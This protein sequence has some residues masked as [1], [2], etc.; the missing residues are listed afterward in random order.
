MIIDSHAHLKHGDDAR[1]EY[2]PEAIIAAMDAAG[3]DRSVVF[4]MSTTTRRSVEMA[5]AAAERFPERLI[6]YAY[7]LPHAQRSILPE[8]EEAV[9][10]SGFRGF[11][12]HAGECR[13]ADYTTG[14]VFELASRLGVPC[15]VDFCGDAAAAETAAGSFQDTAI[16]IAHIGK[17]LCTDDALID[18]F[19]K[20]AQRH[21]NVYL[22][23]SGVV[24]T[25]KIADALT[26]IGASRVLWGTDG[27]HPTPTEAEFAR[28][29]LEKLRTCALGTAELE[30]VLGAGIARLLGI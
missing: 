29:E 14:P 4:A 23:V 1:T 17:Y 26:R 12:L 28:M 18:R 10:Q 3:I 22:D 20:V 21:A 19:I 8:L 13:I 25:W 16:I 9:L 2:S 15:L 24:R 11:K 7:A 6:P 27:P 5:A 30:E